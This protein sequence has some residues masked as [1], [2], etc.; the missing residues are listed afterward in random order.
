MIV[1]PSFFSVFALRYFRFVTVRC[2]H[3]DTRNS[4]AEKM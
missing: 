2:S 4:G 3:I 1:H